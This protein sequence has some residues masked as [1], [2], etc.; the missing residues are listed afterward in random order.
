MM[1][2]TA[3][4]CGQY[5][6]SILAVRDAQARGFDEALL[7][8]ADGLLAEGPG[9]NLFVVRDGVLRTND[10]SASIL[11]GVTRDAVLRIARDLG[12]PVE[13]GPLALEDLLS[14]DEAFFTGTAAEVAPI[15]EVDGAPVG[16]GARGPI[17]ERVQRAFADA[18]SGRDARYAEWL[19]LVLPAAAGRLGA[20]GRP[21]VRPESVN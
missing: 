11:L 19:D 13:V 5:L 4:A 21:G 14:A 17:T 18:T 9:E 7:L 15:R 12:L 1:P 8:N 3:K 20:E 16:R 2:P 6:N 10:E